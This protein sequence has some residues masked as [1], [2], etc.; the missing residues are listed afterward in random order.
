MNGKISAEVSRR[1]NKDKIQ[2]RKCAEAQETCS[3]A[4]AVRKGGGSAGKRLERVRKHCSG[5]KGAEGCRKGVERCRKGAEHAGKILEVKRKPVGGSGDMWVLSQHMT[6]IGND[7][8]INR[9]E[10]HRCLRTEV[11]ELR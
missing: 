10:V 11:E 2:C 1:L 8:Q 6:L 7:W 5:R 9:V 4:E 3:E